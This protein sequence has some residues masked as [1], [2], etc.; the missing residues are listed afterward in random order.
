[1]GTSL[2][3]V[4]NGNAAPQAESHEPPQGDPAPIAEP[5]PAGEPQ[6]QTPPAEGAGEPAAAPGATPAPEPAT[7]VPLKALEEERKGRQ[8][9]KE[10]AIRAEAALDALRTQQPQA[11]QPQSQ[12]Q[13]QQLSPELM[14]LNERMNMSEIMVRQQHQDVDDMLAVFQKA[15]ESNPTLR[16]Q[17]AGERHPWQFMYDTAKRM[18]AMEE[19]GSD[20]EAYKAKVREQLLAEMQAQN[21]QTTPTA[22]PAAPVVQP[23]HA[24]Q[25]SLASARS[26]APRTATA[27]TGPTSLNDIL[28]TKR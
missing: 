16:A 4:L 13:P 5:Q 18:K 2:D 17:L 9:W 11:Q 19:I 26:A 28:N 20:P 15:A 24:I 6:T 22:Q 3:E 23:K 27:W 8:D 21:A 1:M 12:Q 14:L 10:K 7:M 25:P